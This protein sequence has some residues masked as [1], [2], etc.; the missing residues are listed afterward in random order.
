M[1]ITIDHDVPKRLTWSTDGLFTLLDFILVP[2]W[3]K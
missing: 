3:D 1:A 2:T